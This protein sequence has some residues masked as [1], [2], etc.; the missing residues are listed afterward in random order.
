MAVTIPIFSARAGLQI[1]L[2]SENTPEPSQYVIEQQEEIVGTLVRV[3]PPY[4]VYIDDPNIFE[5]ESYIVRTAE[6]GVTAVELLRDGTIISET[7]LLPSQA[8]IIAEGTKRRISTGDYIVPAVGKLSSGFGRR[9]SS[10]IA[11][12]NH[13]GIDIANKTG[14]PIVASDG[15]TVVFAGSGTP[16]NGYG[17]L[18]VI[19]HENGDLTFY[20]HLSK[21]LVEEGNIVYR[22]DE[23]GKMGNTGNSTGPHLHFEYRPGGGEAVDPLTIITLD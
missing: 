23:I 8:Q 22:G 12:T 1:E 4:P 19:E 21:I 2:E 18:V 3:R 7:E 15:G 16:Y 6:S 13:K 10:G 14:T 17:Q 9:Q 5:D 20:G 11:S